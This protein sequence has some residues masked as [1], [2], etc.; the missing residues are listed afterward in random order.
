M[1]HRLSDTKIKNKWKSPTAATVGD[2]STKGEYY[3]SNLH[4]AYYSIFSNKMQ[5]GKL[6]KWQQ[7]KNYHLEI[8]V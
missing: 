5:G 8:G 6:Q 4:N 2:L 3:N 7:R 1:V